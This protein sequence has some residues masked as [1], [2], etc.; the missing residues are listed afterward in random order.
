M[1]EGQLPDYKT[2]WDWLAKLELQEMVEG[3]LPGYKT[4]WDY[5]TIHAGITRE[6]GTSKHKTGTPLGLLKNSWRK[7]V[8]QTAKHV[9]ST[10]PNWIARET[11]GFQ[12][13]LILLGNIW[14]TGETGTSKHKAGT[15]LGFL[16]NTTGQ[17]P[18]PRLQNML[19]LRGKIGIAREA[20]TSKHKAGPPLG[21]L[22]NRWPW[23]SSQTTKHVEITWQNW[24]HKRSSQTTKLI[25]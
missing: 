1:T 18:A 16:K 17:R 4:C 19:R 23:A 13:M 3:Q 22:K 11:P 8:S 21:F 9:E 10:W 25:D 7:A 2:C 6:A 20:G 12:N 5:L 15:P 24:N 14:I